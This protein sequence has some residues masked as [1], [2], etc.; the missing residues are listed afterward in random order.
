MISICA[1]EAPVLAGFLRLYYRNWDYTR[2]TMDIYHT[3]IM[4]YEVILGDFVPGILGFDCDGSCPCALC[5]ANSHVLN[6][7]L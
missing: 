6:T 7:K 2:F 4:D 3:A 1:Y 5:S